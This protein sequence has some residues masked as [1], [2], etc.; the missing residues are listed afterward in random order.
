MLTVFSDNTSSFRQGMTRRAFV[1][2]GTCTVG[3]FSL[4]DMLR[5][6]ASQAVETP[7]VKDI[8]IVFLYFSG[9]A[10]HI[11]TFDPMMGAAAEVRSQTGEVAT[12]IPG[13]TFGGT[14]PRLARHAEGMSVV[15]S[16]SVVR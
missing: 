11:E 5:L 12:T 7:F 1:Q 8:S 15:R 4:A 10:S 6:E 13:V 16:R 2:A 9:G 3:G 14:F